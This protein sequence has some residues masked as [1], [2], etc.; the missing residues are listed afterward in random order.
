MWPAR[1]W[2]FYE[3]LIR[4]IA[5]QGVAP[6]QPDPDR[7]DKRYKHCDVLVVGGGPAGLA[8]ALRATRRGEHVVLCERDVALGGALYAAPATG[9]ARVWL[10]SVKDK[11]SQS[12]GEV[13][14]SSTVVAVHD[15]N[16]VLAVQQVNGGTARLREVLWKI[17]PTRVVL[18]TGAAERPLVFPDNDRPGILLSSAVT[19][20]IRRYAVRP[21]SS[22]VV[23][24]NNDAAYNV[25]PSL[26]TAGVEVRAVVDVR[27]QLSPEVETWVGDHGGELLKGAGVIGVI[28]HSR[29]RAVEVASIDSQGNMNGLIKR[30][31]CDLLCVGGGWSPNLQLFSQAGG[32][33]RYDPDLRGF[34]PGSGGCEVTVAGAAGGHFDLSNCIDNTHSDVGDLSVAEQPDFAFADDHFVGRTVSPVVAIQHKAGRSRKRFV[35]FQTDVTVAAI[36]LAVREGYADVEHVKRYTTAGMGTDQGKTSALNTIAVIAATTGKP[37]S[38]IGHTTQRPP[39]VP[40]SFGAIAGRN[41]KRLLAPTRRSPF[42]HASVAAGAVFMNAGAWK[43]PRYFPL[44]GES[45]HTAIAREVATVHHDAGVIDMS[46]LGK[47]DI[48][49]KD[50]LIFLE[51]VYCNNLASLTLGRVRYSMMLREDGLVLDDGTVSRLSENHYLLTCSTAN[52]QLVWLHLEK[53]RQVHWPELDV[54]MASV[55]NHWASL[56]IAGPKARKVLASLQPDFDVSPTAFPFMTFKSGTLA[57]VEARVFRISFSGELGFEVNVPSGWAGKLWDAVREVG[58]PH[59]LTPYGVEA[60]DVMR[61]EKGFVAAGAE[62]DGRVTPDDLGLGRLVSKNKHFLGQALL[63]RPALLD[64][65]RWQ[66]VGLKPID[67]SSMV[68]P[69]AQIASAAWRGHPLSSMGHVTGAVFGIRVGHPVALAMVSNGRSRTGERV[70]ANSP[71][72][73]KSIQVEITSPVSYDVDGERQRG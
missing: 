44:G 29:V 31:G 73:G 69:A 28:G 18:A 62:I 5:G 35:D 1:A 61:I 32:Q 25:L 54:K 15:H 8:A 38:E 48:Q 49:G 51:R 4:R 10:D 41:T 66:L 30:F 24:A 9:P 6:R 13:M 43:Y 56:A 71:V 47:I 63:S 12:G 58:R 67:G 52:A 64:T 37:E 19:S 2:P 40:V 7:Y 17:R 16:T 33:L 22:A 21:G 65:Y 45:M 60:L 68:P 27:A 36:E 50:A 42:H 72:G 39:Y 57:G 11:L 23:F 3:R 20:Y 46:T 34:L 26:K 53:L 59:N 70:W 55:T 14:L